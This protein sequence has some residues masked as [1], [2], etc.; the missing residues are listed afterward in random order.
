MATDPRF[1]PPPPTCC[2]DARHSRLLPC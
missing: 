1:P 2:C